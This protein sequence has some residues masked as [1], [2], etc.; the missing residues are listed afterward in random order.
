MTLFYLPHATNAMLFKV[1]ISKHF[2]QQL[3]T[4][5][6]IRYKAGVSGWYFL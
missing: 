1:D 4:R 2:H 6:K 5:V 3:E